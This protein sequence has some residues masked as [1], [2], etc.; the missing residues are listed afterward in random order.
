MRALAILTVF[1]AASLKTWSFGQSDVDSLKASHR[2]L[3]EAVTTANVDL[4]VKRVHPR[5]LGFFRMSQYS[6]QFSPR[7]PLQEM[8]PTLLADLSLFVSTTLKDVY[9]VIGETGIVCTTYTRTPTTGMDKKA[10][11]EHNR[12]TF[13]YARSGGSWRLVSW[14]TSHIPLN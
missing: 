3:A 2:L 1:C 9:E 10:R 6:I 7:Q 8:A 5:A 13:V 12:A 11:T 4:F 14:H